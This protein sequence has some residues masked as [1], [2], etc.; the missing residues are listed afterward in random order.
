[1]SVTY[2][3]AGI[4]PDEWVKPG[5]FEDGLKLSVMSLEVWMGQG[6]MG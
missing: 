2:A 1:M 3:H 5:H 4:V 6:C